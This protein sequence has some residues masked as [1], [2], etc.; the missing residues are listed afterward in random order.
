MEDLKVLS[1][2]CAGS[3]EAQRT[4]LDSEEAKQYS[5][6]R[7]AAMDR[8]H[9]LSGH[10]NIRTERRTILHLVL[11]SAVAMLYVRQLVL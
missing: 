5:H 11:Q 6:R 2:N 8:L 9:D 4:L 10:D 7:A 1:Y 3:L